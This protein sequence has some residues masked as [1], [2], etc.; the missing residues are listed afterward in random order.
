MNV[1]S[2]RYFESY[3]VLNLDCTNISATL[4]HYYARK[5]C[6][7][8]LLGKKCLCLIVIVD[9]SGGIE[10]AL[11]DSSLQ[12][13]TKSAHSKLQSHVLLDRGTRYFKA[14]VFTR[15][16]YTDTSRQ[17]L[18]SNLKAWW[19]YISASPTFYTLKLMHHFSLRWSGSI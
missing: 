5:A 3:D 16:K 10:V 4:Q 12:P 2:V 8:I 13:H 18:C 11:A 6:L 1:H 14:Y 7:Q 17:Y 9:E 19:L 15:I